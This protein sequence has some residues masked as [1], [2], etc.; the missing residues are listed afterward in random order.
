MKEK[1]LLS[2]GKGIEGGGEKNHSEEGG[3]GIIVYSTKEGS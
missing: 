1:S 3:G 2:E